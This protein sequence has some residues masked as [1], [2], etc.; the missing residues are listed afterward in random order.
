MG[1]CPTCR[2]QPGRQAGGRAGRQAD[3]LAGRP[4]GRQAGRQA[5]RP[6]GAAAAP[7]RR[8]Y[9]SRCLATGGFLPSPDC[10]ASGPPACRPAC[11]PARRLACPFQRW[12]RYPIPGEE[13]RRGKERREERKE[14][15]GRRVER[16]LPCHPIIPPL[17]PFLAAWPARPSAR[18]LPRPNARQPSRFFFSKT[19]A[20]FAISRQ[21]LSSFSAT[22][23]SFARFTTRAALPFAFAFP[24]PGCGIA[25]DVRHEGVSTD[26]MPGC[27]NVELL[28]ACRPA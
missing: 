7:P 24:A 22:R 17:P 16:S 3:R 21:R 15:R 28:R 12:H 4:A 18:T 25:G 13:E 27:S 2:R 9:R 11:W 5:G 26:K 1:P 19:P 8:P 23:A 10:R 6:A 20:A 14:G